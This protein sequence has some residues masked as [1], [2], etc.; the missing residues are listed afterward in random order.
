MLG[1]EIIDPHGT[2]DCLGQPAACPELASAIQRACLRRGLILELGGRFGSTV[3]LLPPLI[4]T[5]P[6]IDR[7][8]AILALALGE[9]DQRPLSSV[10]LKS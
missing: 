3:R 4:I 2:R 7:V 9:V 10:I 1:I 5:E 6:E 8:A